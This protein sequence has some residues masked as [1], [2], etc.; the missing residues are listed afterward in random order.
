MYAGDLIPISITIQ[1]LQS[2]VDISTRE[3]SNIGLSV[4]CS[5]TFCIRIGPRHAVKPTSILINSKQIEWVNEICYLGVSIVSAKNF[6]INMQNRKQKFFRALNAIFG[7][8]GTSASPSVVISLVE[9]FCV[10]VLLYGLDCVELSKSLLQSLEN[11]YSQLYNKLFH[12]FNKTIIKQCK[13]YSGQMPAEL[14]IANRRFNFLKKISLMDNSYCKYFDI[15]NNELF[16]L[17]NKYCCVHVS[18]GHDINIVPDSIRLQNINFNA[19]LLN[20]FERSLEQLL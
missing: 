9:S 8:I 17:V 4:N 1:D 10:S 19:L 11:A 15:K 5:K 3:I 13:F 6:K 20:Y 12:T 2:L 18:D 7:K 16:L 14:K